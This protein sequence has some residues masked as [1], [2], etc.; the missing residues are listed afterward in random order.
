[1][2]PEEK[3]QFERLLKL[4]EENNEMLRKIRRNTKWTFI[5]GVVKIAIFVVPFFIAYFY[6]EPYLGSFNDTLKQVQ[7]LYKSV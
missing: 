1:M 6:L 4:T 2:N 3:H 5:W 7:E